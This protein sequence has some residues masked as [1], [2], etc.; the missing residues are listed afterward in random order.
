MKQFAAMV[1]A[2]EAAWEEDAPRPGYSSA[3]RAN[4]EFFMANDFVAALRYR[5]D[6]GAL[7]ESPATV[8]PLVGR[9]SAGVWTHR[10]V[11]RL[12]AELGTE[13][14]GMPGG[15]NGPVNQPRAFAAA[16][17]EVLARLGA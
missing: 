6:L 12:A 5:V 9:D 1:R 17:R 2:Q 4:L 7:A 11:H 8:V 15:H 10:A 14:I 16:L 3:R 13:P